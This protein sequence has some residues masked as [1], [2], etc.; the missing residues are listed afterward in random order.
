MSHGLRAPISEDRGENREKS[1][2]AEENKTLVTM[3]S[4]DAGKGKERRGRQRVRWLDRI[5]DSM[6]M[7]LRKVQETVE[8][9]ETWCAAVLWLTEWNST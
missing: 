6:G 8:D 3:H 4:P 2:D 1:W 9:R 7:N 5:T